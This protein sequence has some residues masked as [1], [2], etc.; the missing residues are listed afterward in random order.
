MKNLYK[1]ALEERQS[2][3]A[4]Q[5][6]KRQEEELHRKQQK[7]IKNK[8]IFCIIAVFAV[9]LSFFIRFQC[10]IGRTSSQFTPPDSTM[11]AAAYVLT[12]GTNPFVKSNKTAG[13]HRSFVIGD[14]YIKSNR[15]YNF[16]KEP[17]TS[18]DIIADTGKEPMGAYF[19][20]R[21]RENPRIF[22]MLQTGGGISGV[23]LSSNGIDDFDS[24]PN[25]SYIVT[26]DENVHFVLKE[27]KH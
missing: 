23:N 3:D 22:F 16:L 7:E 10:G 9:G 11:P 12:K 6:R 2:Y 15:R 26:A 27:T 4:N 1:T 21:L 19:T 24:E 25:G 14:N 8:T 13:G 5:L 20:F 18:Y 17:N